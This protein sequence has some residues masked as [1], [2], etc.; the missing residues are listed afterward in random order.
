MP[1]PTGFIA[2]TK[3]NETSLVPNL[4][5]VFF[6]HR[7]DYPLISDPLDPRRENAKEELNGILNSL[8]IAVREGKFNRAK[9]DWITDEL[10]EGNFTNRDFNQY[11]NA[12]R[13]ERTRF[14]TTKA[15]KMRI[16]VAAIAAVARDIFEELPA[17]L[18]YVQDLREALDIDPDTRRYEASVRVLVTIE[19]TLRSIENRPNGAVSFDNEN[20]PIIKINRPEFFP[21]RGEV[22]RDAR[23]VEGRFVLFR[24]ALQVS[25]PGQEYIREYL[26]IEWREFGLTFGWLSQAGDRN[27]VLNFNGVVFFTKGGVWLIGHCSKHLQRIRV[28]AGDVVEWESHNQ[29]KQDYCTG[30]MLTHRNEAK[31]AAPASRTVILK[32]DRASF[33]STEPFE[34]RC[35]F[36]TRTE[37]AAMLTPE[38]LEIV[39]GKPRSSSR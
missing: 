28:L 20:Q 22:M 13:A 23:V 30:E 10:I 19:D 29:K 39:D 18:P 32:R 4:L 38:E 12:I 24:K 25:K 9:Y 3:I 2:A 37:I 14:R 8:F 6:G 27:D 17:A 33:W 31:R 26:H 5:F 1:D 36:L 11:Y 7:E 34:Q 21:S 35:R 15:A 16:N